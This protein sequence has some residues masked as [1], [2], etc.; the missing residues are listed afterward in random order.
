MVPIEEVERKCPICR[1][2]PA[3][4]NNRIDIHGKRWCNECQD[5]FDSIDWDAISER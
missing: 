3:N 5:E 1:E 2:R 4:P